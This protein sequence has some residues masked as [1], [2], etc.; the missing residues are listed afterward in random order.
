VPPGNVEELEQALLECARS[1]QALCEK[2]GLE[3][4]QRVMRLHDAQVE[5]RKLA[6]LFRSIN[7]G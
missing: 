6:Q 2:M 3:G 4:R 1:S 5:G 7:P